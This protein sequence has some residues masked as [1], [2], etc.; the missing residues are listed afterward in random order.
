M[1]R[2]A[3]AALVCAAL[4]LGVALRDLDC[5]GLYYDEVIQAEPALWF[6]H[7]GAG[8]ARGARRNPCADLRSAP[9]R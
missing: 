2:F 4:A 1:R 8:A 3:V 6:L 5:P 9:S 7:A